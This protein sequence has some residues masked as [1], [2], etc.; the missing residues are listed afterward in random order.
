MQ[1]I[2]YGL[3]Q[4]KQCEWKPNLKSN[5]IFRVSIYN[6]QN[7]IKIFKILILLK[8]EKNPEALFF[9]AAFKK[10]VLKESMK[11]QFLKTALHWIQY[12]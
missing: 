5:I 3:N 1:N 6:I 4:N 11:K 8:K 12:F 9:P 7:I 10:W 2:L